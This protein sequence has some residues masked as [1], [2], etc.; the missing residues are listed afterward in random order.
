MNLC[1]RWH[2][3]LLIKLWLLPPPRL[4]R[5]IRLNWNVLLFPS[6]PYIDL[7]H[8]VHPII[9]NHYHQSN[10]VQLNQQTTH[11]SHTA[12]RVQTGWSVWYTS[13]F[14][15]NFRLGFPPMYTTSTNAT[16]IQ[17]PKLRKPVWYLSATGPK[18]LHQFDRKKLNTIMLPPSSSSSPG[19]Q[20]T[21]TC[22]IAATGAGPHTPNTG[23]IYS[24]SRTHP[25]PAAIRAPR[26]ALIRTSKKNR[27]ASFTRVPPACV[28]YTY[29]CPCCCCNFGWNCSG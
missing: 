13:F 29:I 20:Q 2:S 6:R 11:S 16:V 15:S 4:L 5:L 9:E 26:M 10:F 28:P 17:D 14:L 8:F 19:T 25:S 3:L 27:V 12:V 21:D 23:I 24:I 7:I 1:I 22:A 18:Y